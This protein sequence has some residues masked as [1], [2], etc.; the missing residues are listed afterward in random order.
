LRTCQQQARSALD[1]VSGTLRAFGSRLLATPTI[2][3]AR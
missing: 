2:L 1:F 3:Q